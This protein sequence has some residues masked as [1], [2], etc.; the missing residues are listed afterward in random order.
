LEEFGVNFSLQQQSIRADNES[1][2]DDN[3]PLECP[4]IVMNDRV[5]IFG[6]F[7][8]IRS[9]VFS[10]PAILISSCP[11]RGSECVSPE[12]SVKTGVGDK[13]FILVDGCTCPLVGTADEYLNSVLVD[14]RQAHTS[15]SVLKLGESTLSTAFKLMSY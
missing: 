9:V 3:V 14:P 10:K 4:I 11:F 1:S 15:V 8:Y 5:D 13:R 6:F 7:D 12:V 2:D